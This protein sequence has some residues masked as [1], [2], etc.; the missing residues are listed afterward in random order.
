MSLRLIRKS[1]ISLPQLARVISP[2][3]P[4]YPQPPRPLQ[5]RR[6]LMMA[7]ES[8]YTDKCYKPFAHY[9]Q[10]IKTGG[11]VWLSGQIPADVNGKLITGSV[12]DKTHAIVQNTEAILK[13]AGSSLG[14]VV[15]VVVY[16]RDAGIMP[17]FNAVYNPAFP[18]KPARSMVEVSNLPAG[19]DIQVDFIAVAGPVE[20]L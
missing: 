19:V 12:A 9:S 6:Y 14:E 7:V 15:K 17:E 20:K 8:V 2:L 5:P 18:Q 16:V 3:R 1:P 10:A 13:E 11:L 4:L